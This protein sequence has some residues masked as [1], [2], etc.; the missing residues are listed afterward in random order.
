MVIVYHA[1]PEV[2]QQ[3]AEA[4]KLLRGVHNLNRFRSAYYLYL[5]QPTS[6]RAMW[7]EFS[8]K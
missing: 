7:V 8:Y 4:K 2:R 5:K 6:P 3:L 1:G